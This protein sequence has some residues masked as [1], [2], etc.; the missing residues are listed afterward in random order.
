MGFTPAQVDEMS[1]WEFA[2]CARGYARAHGAKDTGTGAVMSET[3]MR[4]LGI[5]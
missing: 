3:R 1:A 2:A 5:L 4:D